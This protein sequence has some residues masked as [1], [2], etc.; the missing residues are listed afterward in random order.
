MPKIDDMTQYFLCLEKQ[1]NLKK[2]FNSGW[3]MEE[4]G[5]HSPLSPIKDKLSSP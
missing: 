1:N 5:I 2:K 3:V 4:G